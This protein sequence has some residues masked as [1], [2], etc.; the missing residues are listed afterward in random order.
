MA[1]SEHLKK[2]RAGRF[3]VLDMVGGFGNEVMEQV[4]VHPSDNLPQ[5]HVLTDNGI[6]KV[7]RLRDGKRKKMIT[8]LLARPNQ[9]KRFK[10][11]LDIATG[12]HIIER[13]RFYEKMGYNK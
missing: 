9:L 8:F 3:D 2:D 1:Y 11:N 10:G 6:I 13:C 7:Y 4:I 5:L 12:R